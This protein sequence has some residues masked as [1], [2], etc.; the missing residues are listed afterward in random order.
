M[1]RFGGTI[2]RCNLYPRMSLAIMVMSK[3]VCVVGARGGSYSRHWMRLVCFACCSYLAVLTKSGVVCASTSFI[4]TIDVPQKKKGLTRLAPNNKLPNRDSPSLPS[5][6]AAAAVPCV[7]GGGV[8]VCLVDS[9]SAEL[10]PSLTT[11]SSSPL[12]P[13]AHT[14]ATRRRRKCVLSLLLVWL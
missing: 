5:A 9:S 6:T 11:S 14:R 8:V 7:I 3:F 1:L 13:L 12:P 4:A 10:L 2:F